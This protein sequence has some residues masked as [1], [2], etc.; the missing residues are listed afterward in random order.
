MIKFDNVTKTYENNGAAATYALNC[1][2]L[3]VQKGEFVFV[4][5]RSG[6]GKSTLSKLMIGEIKPTSGNL[7]VNG[8]CVNALKRRQIPYFRRT[9]GMVFQ[10][11]R[12]LENK[13]VF[14]NVAFAMDIIGAT[15]KQIRRKV[16]EVLSRVGLANKSKRYPHQLSGGEQ[17]RVAIARALVNNPGLIIADEPTGNLDVQMSQEIINM[18]DEINRG[19]TTVLVVTHNLDMVNQMKKRVIEI[20]YGS[21]VRDEERS[22][23]FESSFL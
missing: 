17:Q 7:Y 13:T 4:V 9:V 20:E 21:I 10:D 8:T 14:E 6:A 22:G 16:P 11:F 12:L 3:E 5:G 1:V 15:R 2:S 18:L 19:G 23:N